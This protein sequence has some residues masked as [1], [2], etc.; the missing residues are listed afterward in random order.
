MPIPSAPKLGL[1][2]FIF[3]D[4]ELDDDETLKVSLLFYSPFYYFS[5]SKSLEKLGV[6]CKIYAV[7]KVIG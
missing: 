5:N 7:M 6:S 4:S 2:D 1:H 3:D